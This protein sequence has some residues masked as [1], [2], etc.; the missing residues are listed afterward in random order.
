V[1]VAT[2]ETIQTA[3]DSMPKKAKEFIEGQF[4]QNG[5]KVIIDG[6]EYTL[7]NGVYYTENWFDYDIDDEDTLWEYVDLFKEQVKPICKI[8]QY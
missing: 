4:I 3:L 5:E 6:K 1:I 8:D 7:Y 2:D